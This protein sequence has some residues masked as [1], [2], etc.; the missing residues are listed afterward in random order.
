MNRSARRPAAHDRKIPSAN[1]PEAESHEPTPRWRLWLLLATIL[2]EL[3][4]MGILLS[5]SV[6]K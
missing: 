3:A 1:P 6:R 4:W 5:M 2:L